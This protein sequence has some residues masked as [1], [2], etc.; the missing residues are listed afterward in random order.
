MGEFELIRRYFQRSAHTASAHT[1]LGVGDDC[2]LLH[3]PA[4]GTQW[5]ISTDMLIAGR[6]FFPDV[7]PQKLGHKALAVNLSDLAACGAQPVACTL[8]LALPQADAAWCEAFARGLFALADAHGCELIGGDTTRG[9]VPTISI[10]VMGHVAAG[11]ALLRS[12]ARVGDAIWVSGTLGDAAL[13]LRVLQGTVDGIPD[14]PAQV[15]DAAR[16]RLECP[17]PRVVLG[18]ALRGIASSA[19]DVSDG[20]L[21]DLGHILAAS[22]GLGARIELV[23]TRALLQARQSLHLPTALIDHCTLAGGDDYELCFT[24]AAADAPRIAA[25]GAATGVPLT[26]IGQVCAQPGVVLVDENGACVNASAFASFDHFA[27]TK[28]AS[29]SVKNAQ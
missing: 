12:G 10:T 14:M 4:S 9:P 1:A 19:I 24:A 6:H 5:A 13:A 21:G 25:L 16:A 28:N 23:R 20:L 11:A 3:A 29:T 22:G 7:C 27:D 15:L 2:A 18:Q 26:C 17:T 8:A